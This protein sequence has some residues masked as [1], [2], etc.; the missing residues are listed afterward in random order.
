MRRGRTQ[1]AQADAAMIEGQA[2]AH[3]AYPVRTIRKVYGQRIAGVHEM[4]TAR[5]RNF[6]HEHPMPAATRQ[7]TAVHE[8]GHLV[9]FELEGMSAWAAEISGT[10]FGHQG[11]GGS[12]SCSNEVFVNE[13]AN[14]S[15][16]LRHARAAVAGPIAEGLIARGDVY[17]SVGE[18]I[19]ARVL[20]DC[21]ARRLGADP[22]ELAHAT[23]VQV[24]AYIEAN[25][26]CVSAIADRLSGRRLVWRKQIEKQ[27]AALR[28]PTTPAKTQ[29]GELIIHQIERVFGFGPLRKIKAR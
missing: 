25:A 21:A 8:A 20:I 27:F 26:V 16:L 10:P 15:D 4:L 6:L 2:Y 12:A 11:W 3:V 7:Q 24:V 1:Q 14:A 23:L 5:M 29:H 19:D 13:K 18:L 28:M 9:A 17:G 22:D